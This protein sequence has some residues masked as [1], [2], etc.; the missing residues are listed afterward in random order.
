MSINRL[1]IGQAVHYCFFSPSFAFGLVVGR[2]GE[3]NNL[4]SMDSPVHEKHDGVCLI[5]VPDCI[6]YEHLFMHL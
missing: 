4:P 2:T 5:L 3:K 1:C 6:R